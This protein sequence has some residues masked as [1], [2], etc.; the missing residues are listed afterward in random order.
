[1]TNEATYAIKRTYNTHGEH[2]FLIAWDDE[3]GTV[4]GGSK[5][6]QGMHFS[7][8]DIDAAVDRANNTCAGI[9][10]SQ[11]PDWMIFSKIEL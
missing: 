2:D 1:M 5:P 4:C 10:G 7:A 11:K 9:N 6:S 8:A 3:Y